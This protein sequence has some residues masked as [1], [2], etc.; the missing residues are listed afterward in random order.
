M[1]PFALIGTVFNTFFLSPV[2]NLLVV[3]L[4][5]LNFL[6]IPGA[7]GIGI[8][9][10]TI[11]IRLLVWPFMS[12]QLKSAKKMGELKPHLD[13]L[14]QKHG[15]DQ[16][17]YAQAQMDLFKEHGYNPAA[18]C[19]PSL[20]QLPIIIALYQSISF[21]FTPAQGLSHVNSLLYPF[22]SHLDK[23]PDI[24]FL[25]LLLSSK[26]SEFGKYGMVLLL[27]PIIT[28]GLQFVQSKM[29]SVKPVKEYP[30]DSPKEIQDKEKTADMAS[31][32]Q[33]QMLYLMPLMIGFFSWQ[34]PIGL[35]LYWNTF[36]IF[37]IIQ[38]YKISGLGG[39]E[40]WLKKK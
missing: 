5:V 25:G 22:V 17:S 28:A 26:P 1:N 8:I 32:M 10:L 2:V 19:V 20:I 36:T 7:L 33:S 40:K 18:G 38:Q 13:R 4:H 3:I 12:A 9:L 27:V 21:L 23:M 35:A 37:G 6:H 11:I 24:H 14:K 15:K 30:K 31:S 29:M 16:K 39:L 34:F